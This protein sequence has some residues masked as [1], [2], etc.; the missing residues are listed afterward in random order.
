MFYDTVSFFE[1][2]FLTWLLVMFLRV[3]L[4]IA[5]SRN[6][7]GVGMWIFKPCIWRQSVHFKRWNPPISSQICIVAQENMDFYIGF[8]V[9]LTILFQ[10]HPLKVCEKVTFSTLKSSF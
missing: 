3:V 7:A 1:A 6:S 10:L 2:Y 5:L 8:L 4:Y 9:D